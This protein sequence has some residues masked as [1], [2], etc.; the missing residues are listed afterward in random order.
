MTRRARRVPMR[1][2]PLR[3]A[4]PTRYGRLPE[5]P[6]GAGCK[7][8]GLRLRRFESYTAHFN[9]LSSRQGFFIRVIH[10]FT[11]RVHAAAA[12][13]NHPP[14]SPACKIENDHCFSALT[15]INLRPIPILYAWE[16]ADNCLA[17]IVVHARTRNVAERPTRNRRVAL[18]RFGVGISD[19]GKSIVQALV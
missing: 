8:A 10:K 19:A 9:T 13:H 7:P 14:R 3:R 5:R 17:A 16:R 4:S 6:N 2:S 1:S 15:V 12:E 11:G 18:R